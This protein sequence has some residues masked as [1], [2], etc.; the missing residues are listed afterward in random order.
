[1]RTRF[2]RVLEWKFLKATFGAGRWQ[3]RSDVRRC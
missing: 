3:G 2:K 1:M